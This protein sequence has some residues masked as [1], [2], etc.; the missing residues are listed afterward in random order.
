[1]DIQILQNNTGN[2]I[3]ATI[4][5][6]LCRAQK[7]YIAV[8]FLKYS[9]IIEIHPAL[10]QFL[11]HGGHMDITVGLDFHITEPLAIQY[12]LGHKHIT[13]RCFSSNTQQGTARNFHPKIYLFEAEKEYISIVG[14]ANLTKGGLSSN[15]EVATMITETG[16]QSTHFSH[17]QQIISSYSTFEPNKGYIDKY[18]TVHKM[19]AEHNKKNKRN[20]AL[21]EHTNQ[22]HTMEQELCTQQQTVHGGTLSGDKDR[23]DS[24]ATIPLLIVRVLKN[25]QKNG[26][27]SVS[28]ADIC[29]EIRKMITEDAIDYRNKIESLEISVGGALSFHRKGAPYPKS[30]HLFVRTGNLWSLTKAGQNY[31]AH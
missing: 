12:F 20:P 1:M 14:S 21:D 29:T 5:E 13:C 8:A 16:A 25:K 17:L 19:Q 27:Q 2:N 23:P 26:Q 22:L 3:V 15:C 30:Q 24:D 11:R 18:T 28:A 6:Q 31:P 9:G 7:V 4:R 10:K